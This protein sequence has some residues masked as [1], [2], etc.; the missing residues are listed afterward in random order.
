M[1]KNLLK[2][3]KIEE[4]VMKYLTVY[5]SARNS[6]NA[7]YYYICSDLCKLANIPEDRITIRALLMDRE[8][9]GFPNYETIRR[10]R[11]KVQAEHPEL[12][13]SK[14]VQEAR[15]ELAEV[16]KEWSVK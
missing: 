7:L 13:G 8:L 3:K 16:W 2:L 4:V 12:K 1:T 9:Y 10:T 15:E 5:P 14:E 11:Q 6:D